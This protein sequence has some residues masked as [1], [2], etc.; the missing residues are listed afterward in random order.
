MFRSF[1]AEIFK[2]ALKAYAQISS[3][4]I[5]NQ[6]KEEETWWSRNWKWFVPV[7]FLGGIG[8][9]AAIV[10]LG[11]TVVKSSDVF[12]EAVSKAKANSSVVE[13]LGPSIEEGLFVSGNISASNRS[14]HADMEIP[15]SGQNGKATIFVEATKSAVKWTF[16]TLTV[17]FD[18]SDRRISLLE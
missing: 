13:A 11:F 15:V 5:M 3:G 17:E 6:P 18:E 14:G 4:T 1:S 7:W 12:K 10:F 9:Y 8:F 2:V 16:S